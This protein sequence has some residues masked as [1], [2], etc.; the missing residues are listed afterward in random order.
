MKSLRISKKEAAKVTHD[1][2]NVW[3]SRFKN[4]K[5]CVIVSHSDELNSLAYEYHFINHGFDQYTFVGKYLCE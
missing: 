2:N 3:H 1:I 4:E 5:K